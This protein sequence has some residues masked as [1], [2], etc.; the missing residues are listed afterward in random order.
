MIWKKKLKYSHSEWELLSELLSSGYSLK[1]LSYYF[2]EKPIL[3]E[4]RFYDDYIKDNKGSFYNN[5]RFFYTINTLD[6]AIQN[7]LKIE[8]FRKNL[9]SQFLKSLFYPLVI[10]IFAIIILLFFT[11]TIIPTL[12][13]QFKFD[14]FVVKALMLFPI[15][16][17]GISLLIFICGF[18]LLLLYNLN[19]KVFYKISEYCLIKIKI[20]K[21][22][23][24]YSFLG[25]YNQLFLCGLSSKECITYLLNLN[26]T[27][28]FQTLIQD[29][30]NKL[31]QGIAFLDILEQSSKITAEIKHC[32]KMGFQTN[33]QAHFYAQ[34]LKLCENS[35]R[36]SLTFYTLIIQIIAYATVILVVL[37]V[38]QMM[39]LPLEMMNT[40]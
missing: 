5:L 33:K 32:F 40:I 22:L 16:L 29:I 4:T 24:S 25:Y 10:F 14:S 1:E 30:N 15:I 38:Y 6:K 2:K 23:Y 31:E 35:I 36:K 21:Q 17:K 3:G 26:T 37:L 20:V 19:K 13:S 34:G 7:A 18:I 27:F 39:L 9:K 11:T 12:T 28:Y 8:D